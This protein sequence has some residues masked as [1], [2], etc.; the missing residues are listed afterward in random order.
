M[1]GSTAIGLVNTARTVASKLGC[2]CLDACGFL[3]LIAGSRGFGFGSKALISFGAAF[4]R[5]GLEMR[6]DLDLLPDWQ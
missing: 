6:A 1:G 4:R 3:T 2:N 5:D